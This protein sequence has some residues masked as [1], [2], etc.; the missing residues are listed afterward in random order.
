MP[1]LTETRNK[2]R[3][4]TSQDALYIAEKLNK[5][6]TVDE[7]A[8]HLGISTASVRSVA[9]NLRQLGVKIDITPR[10]GLDYKLLVQSFKKSHP[11]L[12]K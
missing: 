10:K 9:K 1:E 6:Q 2:R 11:Y 7:V 3:R 4:L 8:Q 5:P 12:F